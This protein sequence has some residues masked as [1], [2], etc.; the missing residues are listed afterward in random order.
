MLPGYGLSPL[1]DF[2]PHITAFHCRGEN[3]SMWIPGAGD[4]QALSEGRDGRPLLR[5]C[6]HKHVAVCRQETLAFIELQQPLTTK[7]HGPLAVGVAR[8]PGETPDAA[9]LSAALAPLNGLKRSLLDLRSD[10]AGGSSG[11]A[12]PPGR[13]DRFNGRARAVAE[14]LFAAGEAEWQ[15]GAGT[16][17]AYRPLQTALSLPLP[18][19]LSSFCAEPGSPSECRL[20]SSPSSPASAPEGSSGCQSPESSQ[21]QRRLSQG[22]LR[23]K[24]IREF[25]AMIER[26]VKKNRKGIPLRFFF[27]RFLH[28][29]HSCVHVP[30]RRHPRCLLLSLGCL[31]L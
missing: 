27:C 28:N 15:P 18:A 22:S 21:P 30:R 8:P 26:C 23:E 25:S 11:S 31:T 29:R 6:H 16:T 10:R 1:P 12:A 7:L 9:P 19:P 17:R 20:T 14:T 3:P 2:Q 13:G 5:P 24:S 4:P